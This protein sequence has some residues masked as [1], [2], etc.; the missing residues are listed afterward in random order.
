MPLRLLTHKSLA[1]KTVLSYYKKMNL[2]YRHKVIFILLLVCS[3]SACQRRLGWG[4]LLWNNDDTGMPF[5]TVLPVYVK[6]NIEKKWIVGVPKQF[7]TEAVKDGKLEIPLPQLEVFDSKWSAKKRAAEFSAYSLVYAETLQDGLPIRDEADNSASRVYRLRLGEVIKILDRAEGAPAISTTGDPLPGDWY[8]VLTEDGSTGY[9]FSY[10]LRIF[11]HGSGPLELAENN[12]QSEDDP[13]LQSIQSKKWS[14]QIYDEMIETRKFDL[15]ALM[16]N[17]SFSTGEDTG[18]AN[19][20]TADI[21]RSFQY[22]SIRKVSERSWR[23][24]GTSLTMTLLTDNMLATQFIDRDGTNR[25]A[26]FVALSVKIDDLIAQEEQRREALYGDLLAC[27]PE[28]MSAMFGNLT[29]TEE[30][31]FLW[32]SFEP[33]VP[34]YIP[35][36]VLGRGKIEI[37]YNLSDELAAYYTGVASLV[38]KTIGGGVDKTIHFLY[39]IGSE[40]ESSGSVSFEFLPPEHIKDAVVATKEETP[41][42]I[43]FFKRATE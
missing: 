2:S 14:A 34:D 3:L 38:F 42:I 21:D 23:F 43:Y 24:D 13:L 22:T 16:S 32:D 1:S 37:R 35:V 27:G 10:R 33:L 5:G 30:G 4:V 31:D 26:N 9:C 12:I 39:K 8:K 11:E 29:L 20:F 7:R 40:T 17:W 25:E 41:F 15:E 18:I 19:I 6:S 36:S 28:F